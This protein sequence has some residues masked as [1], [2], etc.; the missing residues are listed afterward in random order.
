MLKSI[1][2]SRDNEWFT[3]DKVDNMIYGD[4]SENIYIG[5]GDVKTLDSLD[6]MMFCFMEEARDKGIA[7]AKERPAK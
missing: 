3:F 5:E 7:A 2:W 1:Y 6:N 4:Y